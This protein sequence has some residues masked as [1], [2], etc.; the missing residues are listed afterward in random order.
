LR[1]G[2]TS[3]TV[4]VAVTQE[5]VANEQL[6]EQEKQWVL[7]FPKLLDELHLEG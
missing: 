6:K 1:I 3:T 7:G 5:Q 4:N 2:A